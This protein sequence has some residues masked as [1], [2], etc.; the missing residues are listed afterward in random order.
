MCVFANCQLLALDLEPLSTP[1]SLDLEPS[2]SKLGPFRFMLKRLICEKFPLAFLVH[3]SLTCN[4]EPLFKNPFTINSEPSNLDLELE[5]FC[6]DVQAQ[7]TSKI[8]SFVSIYSFVCL[9]LLALNPQEQVKVK[10]YGTW[11]LEP[12]RKIRTE[13]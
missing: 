13:N 6:F 10:N 11:V 5:L 1:P 3:Q 12:S 7:K 9:Q 2:S 4:F 8:H